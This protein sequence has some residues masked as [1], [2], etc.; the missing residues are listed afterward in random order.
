MSEQKSLFR[1]K[2]LEQFS[3]PEQLNDYI[4]VAHASVLIVLAAL[5]AFLIGVVIWSINGTID[6][7]VE[8]SAVSNNG[9][10]TAYVP[11][12]DAADLTEQSTIAI[13]G[14]EYKISA[15][16]NVMRAAD[17]MDEQQLAVYDLN[18]NDM[19][20]AVSAETTLADGSYKAR[21][22]M[23]KLRPSELILN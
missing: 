17:V 1:E 19:V 18:P 7:H 5:T 21:V 15:V 22:I 13:N 2:S 16:S 4:R 10:L 20:Y 12:K 14:T 11:E 3:S 8:V 23:A 9:I 6:S